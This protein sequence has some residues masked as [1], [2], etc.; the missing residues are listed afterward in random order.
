[1]HHARSDTVAKDVA[2]DTDKCTLP[3]ISIFFKPG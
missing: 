2:I 1:M 3:V